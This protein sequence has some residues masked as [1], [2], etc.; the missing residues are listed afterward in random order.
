MLLHDVKNVPS[1][2][3]RKEQGLL[4]SHHRTST[5]KSFFDLW[6]YFSQ[7]DLP[8]TFFEPTEKLAEKIS[9][10]DEFLRCTTRLP[11]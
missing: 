7:F 4:S 5:P 3:L 1:Y 11:F 2:D 8:S 9:E 10:E 6:H